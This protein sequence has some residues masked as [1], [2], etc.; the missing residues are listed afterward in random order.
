MFLKKLTV[1][2]FRSF[3]QREF[4]LNPELTVVAG[5]NSRGKTN[6][7]EAVYFILNG[8]GFREDREEELIKFEAKETSVSAV[9]DNDRGHDAY[10]IDIRY[11]NNLVQKTY[12]VN[13]TSKRKDGYSRDLI[14]AVLFTPDQINIIKGSPSL[15][16]E[17]FNKLLSVHDINYKK[18]LVNYEMALRRRNK[19]LEKHTGAQALKEELKFWNEYLIRESKYLVEKRTEYVAY[20]NQYRKI[21]SKEFSIAYLK[22]EFTEKR[23]LEVFEKERVIRKTMIGPQ[24]DDFEITMFNGDISKNVHHYASRSE[25]RLAVFWLKLNEVKFFEMIGNKPILL[26]DD[27]FSELDLANK[28]IVLNL[29]EKYQTVATTTEEDLSREIK[30][31]KTII[32]L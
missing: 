2:N 10:E 5:H 13:K 24:K 18:K 4:V 12:F 30:T 6:M 31:K 21:D 9:F 26:L 15:R 20:L 8:H 3:D 27:I 23:L 1:R 7:L 11:K 14:K 29:V 17:Y 16:R 32:K 25:E 28:K 22:N 19:V